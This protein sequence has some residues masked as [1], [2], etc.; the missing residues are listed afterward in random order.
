MHTYKI[1]LPCNTDRIMDL[2]DTAVKTF[3]N[4]AVRIGNDHS[5]IIQT[6]MGLAEFWTFLVESG[7]GV[8]PDEFQEVTANETID[9]P[10][11]FLQIC[12]AIELKES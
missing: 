7:S 12:K 5:L 10:S 8:G 6:A 4:E 1:I 2:I 3:G 9:I 11:G